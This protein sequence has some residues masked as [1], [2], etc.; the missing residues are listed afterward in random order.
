MWGGLFR[1][2]KYSVGKSGEKLP[3]EHEGL[4]DSTL[5]H[6]LC[7]RCQKQ[8]SFDATA[9]Q[10]VTFDSESYSVGRDGSNTPVHL[11]QVSILY[12]RNCRQGVVEEQ[13]TADH[14]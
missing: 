7:L 8:S 14:S 9:P 3:E 13:H 1:G 11:D 2:K 12:C 6:G 4:P 10:P 5:P